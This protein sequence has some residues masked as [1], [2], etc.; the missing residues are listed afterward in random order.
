MIVN[1]CN[2]GNN[3]DCVGAGRPES[4]RG[5]I[6]QADGFDS[7]WHRFTTLTFAFL[8]QLVRAIII[9]IRNNR[10]FK[11]YRRRHGPQV[12]EVG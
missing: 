6:P 1:K 4:R 7:G 5:S 2:Y 9:F 3:Q 8:A 10:R 12:H 11:S